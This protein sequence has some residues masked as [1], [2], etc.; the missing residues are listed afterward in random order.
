MFFGRRLRTEKPDPPQEAR[1]M[2]HPAFE[3]D[4]KLRF[5]VA[6]DVCTRN[7]SRR[8]YARV[9]ARSILVSLAIGF[10]LSALVLSFAY[11]Y[12]DRP[13]PSW[14]ASLPYSWTHALS[15][16]LLPGWIVWSVML[17]TNHGMVFAVFVGVVV[18]ALV[19]SALLYFPVLSVQL[20]VFARSTRKLNAQGVGPTLRGKDLGKK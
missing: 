17:A 1:R 4:G 5:I 20:A 18:N 7:S 13:E 15:Y 11:Y 6:L 16:V 10:L 12:Q 9:F 19:Y 8:G 14:L 2:G 3:L